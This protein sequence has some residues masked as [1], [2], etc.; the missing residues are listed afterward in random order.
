MG[1]SYIT[2]LISAIEKIKTFYS[3][4][5][6]RN[7]LPQIRAMKSDISDSFYTQYH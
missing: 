3:L 6:K 2:F 5:T 1:T 4:V 7:F